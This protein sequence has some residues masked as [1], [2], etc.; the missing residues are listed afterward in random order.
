[1]PILSYFLIVG[2]VLTG[3]LYFADS[4]MVAGPLPFSTSQRVGLP[5]P[6]KAPAVVVEV[7]KPEIIA[8]TVEPPVEAKKPVKAVRQHKPTRV[9][10]QHKST[11]VVRRSVPQERYAAYPKRE[12]RSIW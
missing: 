1:M 6:Y 12:Y 8:A 2:S 3:L 4:V 11:R 10:R 5:E 9:A 7:P